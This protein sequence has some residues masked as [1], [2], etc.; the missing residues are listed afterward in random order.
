VIIGIALV[1]PMLG[2]RE[3]GEIAQGPL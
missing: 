3:N 2:S 1:R